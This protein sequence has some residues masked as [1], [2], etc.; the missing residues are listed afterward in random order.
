L[1]STVVRGEDERRALVRGFRIAVRCVA[2]W[3]GKHAGENRRLRQRQ[4]TRLDIEIARGGGFDPVS[5]RAEIDA[6][7]VHLQD[8][9]LGVFGLQPERE[10]DL[11]HL[12]LDGALRRQEHVFR[13]LLR[14]RRAAFDH[15]AGEKIL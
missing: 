6:V 9:V 10:D 14:Q 3:C 1:R 7:Q 12:A 4:V 15:P 8:L 2:A 13:K 5:A 11:L